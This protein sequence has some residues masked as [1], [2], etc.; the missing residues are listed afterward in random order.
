MRLSHAPPKPACSSCGYPFQQWVCSCHLCLHLCNRSLFVC[1]LSL[2]SGT[3][4]IS[5]N[6][7]WPIRTPPPTCANQD[8]WVLI[9]PKRPKANSRHTAALHALTRTP[10]RYIVQKAVFSLINFPASFI[11][12]WPSC[13]FDL[14]GSG[15]GWELFL[16]QNEYLTS[17][18]LINR[19]LSS[20]PFFIKRRSW[21]ACLVIG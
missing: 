6:V 10:P 20:L 1:G 17:F 19:L 9:T 14:G 7:R 13:H 18:A 15:H 11:H 12:L 4:V 3:Y 16:K 2:D 21:D 5:Q 8:A